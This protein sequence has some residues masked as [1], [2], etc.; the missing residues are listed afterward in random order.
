MKTTGDM[1]ELGLRLTAYKLLYIFILDESRY[2]LSGTSSG[3][4][5]WT[6]VQLK[7]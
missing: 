1:A 3:Q 6:K 7:A 2:G 4:T 5:N